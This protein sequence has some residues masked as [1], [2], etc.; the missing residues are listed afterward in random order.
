[1]ATKRKRKH[2]VLSV[3]DKLKI[4]DQF[5]SGASRLTLAGEYGVG[6]TTITDIKKNSDAIKK[7]ASV[8]DS[9][10]GSMHRKMMKMAENKDLD[11]SVYTWF[12][13]V[14]S[15]RQPISG[16]LI[17]EKALQMNK[18]LGGNA[19]F[20]ASTSWLLRFKSRHG[21]REL[22]IQG[23]KLLADAKSA[24]YETGLYWKKMPTKTLV[25]KNEMSAPGFKASKS[26]ITVMVCGNVTGT[27]RLP[28]LIV[29]KSKNP[30]CFK[31]IKKLPVIYKNQ[32]NSWMDTRFKKHQLKTGNTG[33][34]LLSIDN[35]P[36]HPSNIS[37]ERENGKFKVV[38]L[39]PNVTSVLQ[40][41]DQEVIESFKRYY[42]KALLRMVML[43]EE[44]EK[45][46]QQVYTEINLKDATYMA[47]DAWATVKDT[48]LVT[49]WNKLLPSDESISAPEEPPNSQFASHMCGLI[50]ECYG[51]E[52]C[53]NENIQDWLECD[54]DDPGYQ[55]LSD[56]E[57][58]ASVIDNQDPW[59]MRKN[60]VTTIVLKKDHPVKKLFTD[61]RQL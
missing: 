27:H 23:E 28:L 1:M 24:E 11:T 8:L 6:K 60:L 12:M 58:I 25:S 29:G 61:L 33:N 57:I 50:K 39:P 44:C 54:A 9:E 41:M 10:D 3:S 56:D 42:R 47:A 21:I 45:T 17:C 32:K 18:K 59:T 43:G 53:D 26:H 20:Q 4:I 37:L 19:D 30:R 16:H 48:T 36:S 15:Q 55:I 49:A 52:E 51:F 40:P 7:F 5:K 13:Q 34:V 2:V 31:G 35:A 38:Y 22:D 46:I 14:C